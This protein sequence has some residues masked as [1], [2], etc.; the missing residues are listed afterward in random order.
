[1]KTRTIKL[2]DTVY[3]ITRINCRYYDY[4]RGQNLRQAQAG[5]PLVVW[6]IAPKVVMERGPGHDSRPFFLNLRDSRGVEYACEFC[7]VRQ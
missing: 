6:S 1:M 5:E 7:Q 2:G 4:P 3:P